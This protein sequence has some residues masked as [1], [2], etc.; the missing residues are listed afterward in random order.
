MCWEKDYAL[1]WLKGKDKFKMG[2][3]LASRF[4]TLQANKII[5]MV[6]IKGDKEIATELRSK[7]FEAL[8]PVAELI[9][10]AEIYGFEVGF[11]FGKNAFGKAQIQVINLLKKY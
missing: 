7:F 3:D 6:S 9:A 8:G 2:D 11:Q 10:E 4:T 5:E 1:T